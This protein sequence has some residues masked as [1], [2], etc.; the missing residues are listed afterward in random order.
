MSQVK[1]P[2][3]LSPNTMRR[4]KLLE[5]KRATG[6]FPLMYL[7]KRLASF[8]FTALLLVAIWKTWEWG[9]NRSEGVTIILV[10]PTHKRSE[11]LAD[12]IRFSQTLMHVRDVHWIVIEDSNATVPAVERILQRSGVPYTYFYTTTMPGFPSI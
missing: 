5:G 6:G 11:R 1:V 10:T 7:A 9:L 4:L 2:L 8:A 3:S 12:M